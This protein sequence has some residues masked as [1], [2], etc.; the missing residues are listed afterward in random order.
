MDLGLNGKVAL[1]TA[2]SQGLGR[3]VALGLAREGAR[4]S[5][6]SR[7]EAAINAVADEIRGFGGEVL[8]QVADLTSP[9]EINRLVDSTVEQFGGIDVLVTNA[10]GPPGGTFDRFQDDAAWDAAYNLTLMSAVRLIRATLPSMRSRGGG[11]II[12]MTSSSVKQPIPNLLLSNVFRAGVAALAKSLADDLAKE[13]IR[14][15]N[16][17]PGR[18]S[19][20]RIAQ[21]DQGNAER[22]G[23]DI[24]VIRQRSLAAI[25]MGRLGEPDEFA[26]MAVFLA[27]ER[28]SYIT[29]STFQVDGG[30]M[31]SLW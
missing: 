11:S 9:E 20:Q 13:G 31:R 14:V 17:V 12:T 4:L 21:L 25:P 3:A 5:I 2:S 18:I 19:T 15:N 6:C 7:D 30:Q 1:V 24:S 8:A 29:G 22:E 28:A 23:V 16:L 26:D 27:S 10:G